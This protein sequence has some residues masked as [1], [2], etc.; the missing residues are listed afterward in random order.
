MPPAPWAIKGNVSGV[1]IK[2][3]AATPPSG[4]ALTTTNCRG[5]KLGPTALNHSG[6]QDREVRTKIP[7][8]S[9]YSPRPLLRPD[10]HRPREPNKH[11]DRP[12]SGFTRFDARLEL[13]G[14]FR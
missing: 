10:T 1:N 9:K 5:Q 6:G 7:A 4:S 8:G 11:R 12:A 3:I 14:E 13:Q 2:D